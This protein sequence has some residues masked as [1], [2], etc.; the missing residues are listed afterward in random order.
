MGIGLFSDGLSFY[1]ALLSTNT[2]M[3]LQ[4]LRFFVDWK[5]D[6]LGQKVDKTR[7]GWTRP[8]DAQWRETEFE[9]LRFL[10]TFLYGE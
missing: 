5:L 7:T 9:T 3:I 8:P 10:R 2:Y 4:A 6:K 1:G